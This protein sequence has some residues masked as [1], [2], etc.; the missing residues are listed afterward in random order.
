MNAF[1]YI[2]L[3]LQIATDLKILDPELHLDILRVVAKAADLANM[4]IWIGLG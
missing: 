2:V 3:G 4:T 1:E